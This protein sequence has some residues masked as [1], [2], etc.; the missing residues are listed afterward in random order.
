MQA[1][2]ESRA[3]IYTIGVYDA[4][5]PDKNPRA[6]RRLA[7]ISGGESFLEVELS[8]VKGICEEIAAD[9]RTRYTVGYVPTRS[10]DEGALR[11]IKVAV[12]TASGGKFLVHTRTRYILP[13]ILAQK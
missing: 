3:T 1:V 5:D 8:A 6:L 7:S 10:G 4:D 9:I 11:K 13:P 12:T 2:L